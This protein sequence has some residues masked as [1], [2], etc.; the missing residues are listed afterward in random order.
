MAPMYVDVIAPL[1]ANTLEEIITKAKALDMEV[2]HAELAKART[3]E[4]AES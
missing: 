1:P 2:V 4:Q 3:E